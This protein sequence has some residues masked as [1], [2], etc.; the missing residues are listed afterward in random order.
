ML[1]N[2]DLEQKLRKSV[3]KMQRP[4]LQRRLYTL[5]QACLE[6][7]VPVIVVFEGWDA[8]G[9]EAAL[10]TLTRDLD[11][12]ALIIHDVQP[13]RTY[14]SRMPWLW[15]FWLKIPRYGEMAIFY[16]SWYEHVLTDRVEA[17][18][19]RQKLTQAYRDIANFE[20]ALADDGYVIVKIF[21]HISQ[22]EQARRFLELQNDPLSNWRVRPEHWE[23]HHKRAQYVAAIEE[24]LKRTDA[25]GAPWTLIPATDAQ[26]ARIT[27]FETVI[28]RIERALDARGIVVPPENVASEEPP[29]EDAA[30]SIEQNL[31]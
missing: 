8:A 27:T 2:V 11:P 5:Q 23:R 22:E 20:R 25:P 21:F 1:E 9:K 17:K 19:P 3:Y 7:A 15:R 10:K 12:R 14:E 28:T 26:W 18:L 13:P 31:G 30:V 4:H 16:H 6:A 24:M 29:A